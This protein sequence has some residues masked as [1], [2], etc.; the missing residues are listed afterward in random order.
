MRFYFFLLLI[1]VALPFIVRM[2]LYG[3]LSIVLF[4]YL[5][6]NI[7]G[8]DWF[9][10]VNWINLATI[11]GALWNFR[12]IRIGLA[13]IFFLVFIFMFY[14]SC[15]HA[16]SSQAVAFSYWHIIF[17]QFFSYYIFYNLSLMY[18]SNI[19]K[20]FIYVNLLGILYM[21]KTAICYYLMTGAQRVDAVGGQGGG[22]NY[23]AM[24]IDMFLYFPIVQLINKRKIKLKLI[25]SII[26]IVFIASL[27][28][29]GSRAGF[30][31]FLFI[32][33]AIIRK[34][35]KTNF[36][37]IVGAL[38]L[39][40]FCLD[41]FV[42]DYFWDRMET[43]SNYEH[44]ESASNR[45]VEWDAALLLASKHIFFGIGPNNFYLVSHKLTGIV[46]GVLP[47][48][49]SHGLVA[50]NMLIQ[51]LAEGGLMSVIPFSGMLLLTIFRAFKLSIRYDQLISETYLCSI[52]IFLF[53]SLFGS[54]LHRD[55]LYWILGVINGLYERERHNE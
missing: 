36:I 41:L 5:N 24:L 38:S 23:L 55:V 7:W 43:I 39:I 33:F 51:L 22:A 8:P 34:Y 13:G 20:L 11:L 52:L 1:T 18:G 48:G 19:G 46:V 17:L 26:I 50:H 10:P 3:G 49:E 32:L 16:I 14:L 29:T 47:N 27:I 25:Y 35:Y 45:L 54:I 15:Y 12:K 31:G 37:K 4:Y 44:E 42:P 6:P 40:A 9:R 21:S 28:L 30:L 53:C 2:P